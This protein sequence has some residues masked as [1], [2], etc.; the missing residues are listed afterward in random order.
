M[1]LST[2]DELRKSVG[3]WLAKT[4]LADQIPDFIT[5]AEAQLRR[6]IRV[7]LRTECMEFEAFDRVVYLPKGFAGIVSISASEGALNP[8]SLEAFAALSAGSRGNYAVDGDRVL[9]DSTS[10]P[11]SIRYRT[12][13]CPLSK[14]QRANW[15]LCDHPDA[16]LYGALLQAAPY[17]AD[18]ERIATW[19]GLYSN[20]VA[21][22]NRDAINKQQTPLRM[23]A[24]SVV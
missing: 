14:I 19:G 22:I 23:Q 6:D 3:D 10:I 15:L 1:S 2:Y 5:L 4:N 20:A 7:P 17:L 9:V 21:S 8:L 13:F 18:D 16:Y 12:K 11:L 24:G